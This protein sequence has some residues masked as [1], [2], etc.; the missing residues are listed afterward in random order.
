MLL[1]LHEEGGADDGT[2]SSYDI[3]REVEALE[4]AVVNGRRAQADFPPLSS[5]NVLL[6][7]VTP[8]IH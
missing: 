6:A 5:T 2:D 8:R 4:A 7:A 3:V 1:S